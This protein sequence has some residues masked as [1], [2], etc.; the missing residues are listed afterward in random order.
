MIVSFCGHREL[1]EPEKVKAWLCDA[2]RS[3]IADGADLFVLG[4]YGQ[5]DTLAAAVV[6]EQKEHY[7]HIRSVLVLPYLEKEYETDLYDETVYP[8]L[9]NVP[10]R[11]AVSRRN[12]Y[13]I[14]SADAVVACVYYTF[15]GAYKTLKYAESK[16]KRILRCPFVNRTAEDS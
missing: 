14:D 12:E 15:G 8:P 7:P 16:G 1:N 9:E 10:K 11:Y 6:H 2:V 5:F 3:L 13:M 4:G